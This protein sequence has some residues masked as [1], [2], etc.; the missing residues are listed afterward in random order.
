LITGAVFLFRRVMRR[1]RPEK[2]QGADPTSPR[3]GAVTR[4]YETKTG[5]DFE[6]QTQY[7]PPL[8][9]SLSYPIEQQQNFG[10]SYAPAVVGVRDLDVRRKTMGAEIVGGYEEKMA[11]TN[12]AY[13][14]G[15]LHRANIAPSEYP[16]NMTVAPVISS[17]E[18]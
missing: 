18:G 4:F 14:E 9:R 12:M 10:G 2:A 6:P 13:G 15:E 3:S 7:L 5:G 1:N 8:A 11:L 17:R 16:K